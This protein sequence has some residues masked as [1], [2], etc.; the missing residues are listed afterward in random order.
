MRANA[1]FNMGG[2]ARI[3]AAIRAF[4][5]IH[6]P[7]NY[8][9]FFLSRLACFFSLA[10]NCGFFL[11]SFLTSLLLPMVELLFNGDFSSITGKGMVKQWAQF[12]MR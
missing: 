3:Q 12:W 5:H 10:D 11:T 1:V 4:H 6:M 2:N 8:L 7:H 9:A